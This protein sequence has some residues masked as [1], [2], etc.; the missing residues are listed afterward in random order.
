VDALTRG[1]ARHSYFGHLRR[2]IQLAWP[3]V[4]AQAIG[5]SAIFFDT[6][7]VGHAG[8]DEL[9][10]LGAGRS[11][12]ILFMIGGM[13]LLNGILVFAA[14]SHG[15]GQL[16]ECGRVWRAG[17]L[18]AF[19]I[20]LLGAL[21][22]GVGGSGLLVLLDVAPVVRDGGSRYLA[23]V[24]PTVL[25]GLMAQASTM[26]LQ[27]VSNPK[28][29]MFVQVLTLPVNVSLNW[30]FIYGNLGAPE[31]GAAG[32]ALATSVTGACGALGLFLFVTNAPS[33]APFRPRGSWRNLWAYGR[34]IRRFGLP[35]GA[36]GALEFFGMTTLMMFAGRIGALSISA[37]EVAFNLHL[38]AFLV[39]IG[40]SSATAV[41]VGNAVGR[42]DTSDLGAVV[43]SGVSVGIISMVPFLAGYI[44]LPEAFATL[45][46]NDAE[47]VAL[48]AGLMLFIAIALPFDSVQMIVLH[49][50][51]AIGD[52]WVSSAL[53]VLA[54]F[55]IM[56]TVG[57]GLAFTLGLGVYG[58]AMAMMIGAISAA[59]M[60]A[61]RF[62]LVRRRL[63]S[64]F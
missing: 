21:L 14:R 17:L 20:G 46:I 61:S 32:A 2:T 59:V 22:L 34:T 54:F 47:V 28:P 31:M 15:A 57:W 38:L 5:M 33:L 53:Q 62:L 56:V 45:F 37:L 50:L 7:M 29:A 39:S 10:A 18:Y 49:S 27:G 9:A 42:Q 44:L 6:I 16:A 3:I 52:Q 24:A 55:F 48:T 43:L 12:F 40:V 51:R 23:F 63:L 35:V 11:L 13:G 64:A 41:R 4:M 19:V 60:L 26:F 25:F 8:R 36:A 30:V 1:A 58:L